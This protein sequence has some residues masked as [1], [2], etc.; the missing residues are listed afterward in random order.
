MDVD[1][2]SDQLGTS[3]IRQLLGK[4]ARVGTF[5]VGDKVLLST[6]RN[7]LLL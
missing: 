1:N 2:Y 3:N 7:E 6:D 5:K 4:R